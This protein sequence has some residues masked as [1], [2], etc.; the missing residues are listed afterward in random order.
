MAKVVIIESD[1]RFGEY[2]SENV[3]QIEKSQQYQDISKKLKVVE[4]I[5]IKGNTTF[6]VE[7]KKSTPNPKNVEQSDG[8]TKKYKD[9]INS[10][11]EKFSD[12]IA[13]CMSM[14]IGRLSKDEI[15][16][17]MLNIDYSDS[18]NKICMVLVVKNGYKDSLSTIKDHLERELKKTKKIWHI[19]NVLAITEQKAKEAG[20]IVDKFE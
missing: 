9:Y 17:T 10:I 13:V 1:M 6:F 19:D 20:L 5:L 16:S 7:A 3:F 14:Q 18:K 12:S 15:P 4:F 8:H 11:V 2:A